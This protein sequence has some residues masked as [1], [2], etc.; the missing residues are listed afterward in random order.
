MEDGVESIQPVKEPPSGVKYTLRAASGAAIVGGVAGLVLVGP[1]VAIVAA[2]GAAVV[3]ATSSGLA[4]SV[5]R[6]SGEIVMDTSDSISQ[7]DQEHKI[8]ETTSKGIM[9]GFNWITRKTD[10]SP[11]Q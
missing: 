7:F 3:A 8:T 1:I 4:G 9:T 11:K 5:T 2:G 10:S 6:K